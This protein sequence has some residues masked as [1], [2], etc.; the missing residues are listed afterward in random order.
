MNNILMVDIF[1]ATAYK[2]PTTSQNKVG[3]IYY[4]KYC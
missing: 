1:V 3:H 2:S 4:N